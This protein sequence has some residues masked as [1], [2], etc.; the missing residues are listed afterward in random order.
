[1]VR[2]D[3]SGVDYWCNCSGEGSSVTNLLNSEVE[4]LFEACVDVTG[5]TVIV[6]LIR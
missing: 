3:L 2:S 4:G 5:S 1:M 6:G